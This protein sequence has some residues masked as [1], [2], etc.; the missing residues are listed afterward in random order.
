MT[1][2]PVRHTKFATWIDTDAWMEKMSGPAWKNILKE[3]ATLVGSY[4][5]KPEVKERISEYLAL[6]KSLSAKKLKD[7]P[8]QS[9]PIMI[10]WISEFFKNMWFINSPEKIHVCRDIHV[11]SDGVYCT[12]DIG[13]GAEYF[14]LQKWSPY[15]KSPEYK[16]SPVGP[17]VAV[18]DM[19]VYYLGVKNKLHYYQ[20]WK[21]ENGKRTC[22]YKE[23][24]DEINLALHR[25]DDGRILFSK[26]NSQEFTYYELPSMKQ[27]QKYYKPSLPIKDYGLDWAWKRHGFVIT[28]IYG[29]KIFWKGSK[30]LLELEAGEI[31]VD[32]YAVHSGVLPCLVYITTPTGSSYYSLNEN[33]LTLIEE[34]HDKLTSM[35]I[36][37]RSKDGTLVYG[38]LTYKKSPKCLLAIGYGAYGMESHTSPVNTR[39][40]PLIN[41]RWAV[42][43]TFIRGGGDHNDSWAK[44][45][46]VEGR[47]K[48]IED[49]EALVIV[50]QEILKI[51][52]EKTAI[53]GR[54]AGGLLMGGCLTNHP[55]GSLASAV[56]AEVP[57][58]DELRTTT[59]PELP[60]TTLEHNEFGNP[61][62]RLEDF[63]SVGLL[64]PADSALSFQSPSVFVLTRTAEFDS[65]VFAYEPV[66]WIRRLRKG[67]GL[68]L[69][70]IESGQGHF[71]P[72]DKTLE[73]WATDCALLD[74]WMM[75]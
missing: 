16:I 45:G 59:N 74:Y 26:E 33:S 64:S 24:S 19:T 8:F 21:L 22:I 63:L 36:H 55:D 51:G 32:P 23:P 11:A 54:S 27:T 49:F 28:K 48:T 70:I 75:R 73:Q 25:L 62:E 71:T 58:V 2:V 6:Y 52:P 56:Y 10:K 5:K 61:S 46:R 14:E 44:A 34:K 42:L 12:V 31:L 1:G 60:L 47:N 66:K 3:E 57:Y 35:R 41:S 39:W 13:D 30:K 17:D 65:Q 67:G 69:A 18:I 68:K 43:Y 4:I 37:G 50:A 53:Y 72:P 15:S 7:I 40:G 9:G 38:V 20:L 29:K